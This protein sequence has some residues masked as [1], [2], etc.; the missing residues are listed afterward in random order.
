MQVLD[1][2]QN[3]E[4]EA[5]TNVIEKNCQKCH[6]ELMK[7]ICSEEN[8]SF[9]SARKLVSAG[10]MKIP[11]YEEAIRFSR[12]II[13]NLD[14]PEKS[15][16]LMAPLSEESGGYGLCKN[17]STNTPIFNSRSDKDYL[18]LLEAVNNSSEYLDSIKRFDMIDFVVR[19]EYYRE[20]K[21][22]GVLTDDVPIEEV[23]PYVADSIYWGMKN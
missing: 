21:R 9:W 10:W 6:S 15:T 1:P 19:P 8:L 13:Y 17:E 5:A 22:Y 23:N 12:H 7:N 16:I 11:K 4:W 14:E 3:K 20:M 18:T 2:V